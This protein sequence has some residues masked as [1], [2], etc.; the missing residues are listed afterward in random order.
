MGSNVSKED[1][2]LIDRLIRQAGCMIG[3]TLPSFDESYEKS[4]QAKF[5][6]ITNDNT[7]PLSAIFHSAII[8]RSGRMKVP[9]AKTNRYLS[10]F[11]PNCIKLHN[12]NFR[13]KLFTLFGIPFAIHLLILAFCPNNFTISTHFL[14]FYTCILS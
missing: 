12:S 6:K 14:P 1:K 5:N 10:S 9:C 4:L 8:P 3:V 2:Y 7:H 13:R 11:V